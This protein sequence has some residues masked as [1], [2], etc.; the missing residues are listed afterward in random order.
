MLVVVVMRMIAPFDT[1]EVV[2]A[3][4]EGA[5]AEVAAPAHGESRNN[6]VPRC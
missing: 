2:V 6:S 3:A 4:M 1:R 5:F